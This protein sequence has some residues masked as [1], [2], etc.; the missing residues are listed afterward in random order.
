MSRASP[1]QPDRGGAVAVEAPPASFDPERGDSALFTG[2]GPERRMR[3]WAVLAIQAVLIAGFLVLWEWSIVVDPSKRFFFSQPSA[4]GGTLWTWF[5]SG[6]VYPH[7]G[8]TLLETLLGFAGGTLL[9]LVTGFVL[10]R[11]PTLGDVFEPLL[12]LLNGMPR[13]VLAPLVILWL[14]LGIA[15]KV[16][17]SVLVVFLIVFYAVYTGIREVDQNLVANARVLGANGRQLT[18]HVLIPSALTWIFSSLRVSVGFA[19]VGA[20][21]AEYL[22]SNVGVGFLIANAQAFFNATGVFAG[23]I[24]LMLMVGAINLG[25]RAVERRFSAWKAG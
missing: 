23:L 20:V 1:A 6:S 24:V 16:A 8:I 18:W 13:V 14:G 5:S 11:S 2:V 9:G 4:I 12:A 15:S 3:R 7:I 22:G 10:A 21:V 19:L 17:L 25:L